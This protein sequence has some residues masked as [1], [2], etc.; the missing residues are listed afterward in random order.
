MKKFFKNFSFL[1]LI[2][3]GLCVLLGIG[4]VSGAVM[5]ANGT[6]VD[7][8]GGGDNHNPTGVA[9]DHGKDGA[10]ETT[11]IRKLRP[12]MIKDPVDQKLVQIRPTLTPF[13]T[14]MR[15]AKSMPTNNFEFG[16]YSIDTRP[17]EDTIVTVV[18]ESNSDWHEV[19][20]TLTVGAN[21][22]FSDTDT[23]YV[24][25][26]NGADGSPLMLY[27]VK[28]Q[29]D[30]KLI[31]VAPQEQLTNS[32]DTYSIAGLTNDVKIYRLGRAAAELDVQSPSISYLPTKSTGYCQI[33][34]C[35]IS[36]SAYEKMMDKEIKWDYSEI[37]EQA[38]YE[39]RLAMEASFLFGKR[40]KIYDPIKQTDIYTT[41]GIVRQIKTKYTLD[42]TP[43]ASDKDKGN[44]ELVKL[45]K[46][47]FQGNSGDKTRVLFAGSDFVAALSNI[48]SVQKQV[49]AGNTEVAWGME[50]KSIKT[51]FGTLLL[52]QHDLFDM[53]GFSDKAVVIDP[54]FIRKWQIS[55]MERFV[56][57]AKKAGIMN[58]DITVFTE[59]AGTA[60][61]YPSA[62]CIVE[63][64]GA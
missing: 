15:Y 56:I 47:I 35:Q 63:L 52:M 8:N 27:V 28:K 58:G 14:L 61:Y 51:N 42:A 53:Y 48:Q 31:V 55:N 9:I 23:I 20:A 38:L 4:D 57:D 12:E 22:L 46:N 54:Q 21:K 6:A 60:V 2:M 40:S 3:L 26:V 29:D 59:A 41:D 36:Q 10:L 16:W 18:T 64:A 32:S 37:E 7:I 25:D 17:V 45:C 49:D 11:D 62:H 33:F 19:K 24:P 39:F 50:W 34:K 44:R 1:G 43:D 30:G 5:M 13:D